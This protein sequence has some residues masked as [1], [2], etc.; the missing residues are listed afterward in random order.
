MLGVFLSFQGFPAGAYGPFIS[1]PA[2]FLLVHNSLIFRVPL[3]PD[4]R[5]TV[6]DNLREAGLSFVQ[7]QFFS[8]LRIHVSF[9]LDMDF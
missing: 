1:G 5:N 7:W 3:S 2:N 9:P 6:C 4:T 8:I